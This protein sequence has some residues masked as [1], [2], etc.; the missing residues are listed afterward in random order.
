M[1]AL[2]ES[3]PTA[4][5]VATV[6]NLERLAYEENQAENSYW[7]DLLVSGVQVRGRGW[8]WLQY[9]HG[10]CGSEGHRP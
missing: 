3:G 8:T 7:H 9:L 10:I 2:Q 5:E 6:V 1:E 4:Q